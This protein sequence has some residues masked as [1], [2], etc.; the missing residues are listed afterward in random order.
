MDL[1]ER[2]SRSRKLY[3]SS[4]APLAPVEFPFAFLTAF[5]NKETTVKRLRSGSSNAS[6][7]ASGV[8]QRNNVHIAVCPEGQVGET[9]AALRKSPKTTAAKAK[10][11]LATDGVVLEAE[12]LN[13]GETIACDYAEFADHFG[14]FLPLAGISIVRQIKTTRSTSRRPDGEQALYRT[15]EGQPG[16]GDRRPPARSKPIHGAADFL[17]LCGG[18]IFQNHLFTKTIEQMSDSQ[19]GNAHEVIGE[20]F[21]AMDTKIEDRKSAGLRLWADAFPYVIQ[22]V[23]VDEERRDLGMHYTSV[24]NILK[25]LNP[26][27]LD[28]LREKL[29]KAGDNARK[30]RNLRM[31]LASI[32][33]FD[34]AS[35]SGN[36]LVIA[37]IKMR[38]ISKYWKLCEGR[39]LQQSLIIP[40]SKNHFLLKS[41]SG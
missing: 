30:L 35:G 39:R 16:L 33:V 15:A 8:L 19:S 14:F 7:V 22:A 13:S 40:S 28:D 21:R 26:L 18:H 17:L 31:R 29:E 11:I 25:V 41:L 23:A 1:H 38:E 3:R 24:P 2:L 34:P 5:G 20:L 12:D 37:Y 4:L 36:F 27:F 9:L 32:R 10:F 6:D